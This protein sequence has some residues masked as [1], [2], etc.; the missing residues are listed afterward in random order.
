M[1]RM[2]QATVIGDADAGAEAYRAAEKIGAMLARHG[3]IVITGGRGGVMEAACRGARGAGGISI[4][5]LPGE[6]FGAANGYCSI[7]I[8]T[9]LGHSRNSLTILAGDFVIAIGGGAGTLSELCF[10]WIHEKPV[11][12][13]TLYG[14]WS[15]QLADSALDHR[16]KDSVIGCHSV[17][18]VEE[19]ALAICQRADLNFITQRIR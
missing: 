5:I 13:L 4:G 19:K 2:A 9:G 8:P 11:L 10:A 12:A 16:R 17:E 6:E 15:A 1:P 18:E 7:V 3:I 14:G